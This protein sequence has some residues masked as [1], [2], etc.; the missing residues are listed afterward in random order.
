[1]ALLLVEAVLALPYMCISLL[2]AP[3]VFLRGV[4]VQH[5]DIADAEK[6]GER[7]TTGLLSSRETIVLGKL[8]RSYTAR[9][10]RRSIF[11]SLG[12]ISIQERVVSFIHKLHGIVQLLVRFEANCW[13]YDNV[14]DQAHTCMHSY[15]EQDLAMVTSILLAQRRGFGRF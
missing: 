12:A 1:M 5:M 3:P 6:S 10:Q 8:S 2:L 4:V 11:S 15:C 13:A 9:L 14:L 7:H